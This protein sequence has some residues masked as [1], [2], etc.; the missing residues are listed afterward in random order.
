MYSFSGGGAERTV[1][2]IINNLNR[3]EFEPI[4]VIGTNKD[5]PYLENLS[6]EVKII[7]LNARKLRHSW[8]ALSKCINKENPDF[9]FSTVNP[10]NIILSLSKMFSFKKN[11][12]IVREAN[13][14]TQAGE[15][16]FFNKILTFLSYNLIADKVIALSSGV[17]DDLINNFNI[18]KNKIEVIHN[19]VEVDY[20]REISKETVDDFDFS[21]NKKRII[22]VGRLAEQ[23]DYQTLLNAF[24]IIS[25]N[26]VQLIILGKGPLEQQLKQTCKGL[27]IES[28]VFFLGF[29]KNPYKYMS[30][31]DLFVLSS[32]WEGFGHVIVEAMANGTPVIS[33]DCKSGPAEILGEDEYG[34]LVP[35]EDPTSLALK[36]EELLDNNELKKTYSELAK[37]RA[38]SFNS[39]NI[40]KQ[41]EKIFKMI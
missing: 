40:V 15:G 9:L 17:Q 14:R 19:P 20:I 11:K 32:K 28:K 33:T 37:I 21:E 8:L 10:N 23:K 27:G 12:L 39:K 1:L 13:N 36:I 7:N 22:A 5:A 26:N 38:N 6:K 2:N 41:Y 18:N 35:T 31:S 3:N 4:L 24:K 29:K 16:S 25:K 30:R 34:V